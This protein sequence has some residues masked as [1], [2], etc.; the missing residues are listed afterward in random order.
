M[1]EWHHLLNGHEFEQAPR[2]RGGQGSLA[3]CSPWGHK[4]LVMTERLNS[5]RQPPWG[6][7]MRPRE[8]ELVEG[9]PKSPTSALTPGRALEPQSEKSTVTQRNPPQ[10]QTPDI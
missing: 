1:V 8:G 4:E 9:K 10:L 3:C 6:V 5:T 2:D 7:S